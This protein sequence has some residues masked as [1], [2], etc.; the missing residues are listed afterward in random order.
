MLLQVCLVALDNTNLFVHIQT[1]MLP[2]LAYHMNG[3]ICWVNALMYE[4]K[5]IGNVN[6]F[7]GNAEVFLVEFYSFWGTLFHII[8][9][10]Y[11]WPSFYLKV[12]SVYT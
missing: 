4:L 6:V 10:F 8:P 9:H 1:E 2:G 12:L 7:S 11:H 3:K 5:A